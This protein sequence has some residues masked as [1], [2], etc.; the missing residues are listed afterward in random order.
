MNTHTDA[1]AARLTHLTASFSRFIFHEKKIKEILIQ[2]TYDEAVVYRFAQLSI[3]IPTKKKHIYATTATIII[4]T[5]VKPNIHAD[6]IK[7]KRH[8]VTTYF[9]FFYASSSLCARYVYHI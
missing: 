6:S 5:S 2:P 9:F 4:T 7:A 8:R 1:Y 3:C